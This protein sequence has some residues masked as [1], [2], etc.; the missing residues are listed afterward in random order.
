MV[1]EC[2][3][4]GAAFAVYANGGGGLVAVRCPK[5]HSNLVDLDKPHGGVGLPAPPK[6]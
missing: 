4:C 1:V 3:T 5:G 6:E 2:S